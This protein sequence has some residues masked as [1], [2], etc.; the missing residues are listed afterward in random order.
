MFLNKGD[1][2]TKVNGQAAGRIALRT[3]T[4]HRFSGSSGFQ[5]HC[6]KKHRLCAS[7]TCVNSR[8]I[9]VSMNLKNRSNSLTQLSHAVGGENG[10]W[11][12]PVELAK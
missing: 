3:I 4:V 6:H 12:A 8:C 9:F 5:V 11:M 2:C 10:N 1:F 7:C